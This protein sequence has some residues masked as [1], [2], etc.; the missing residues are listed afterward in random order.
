MKLLRTPDERFASLP[1]Y[2]FAPHYVDDL[3]GYAGLRIHYLDAGPRN[4]AKTYLCLHGQPTWSYLYRHMIPVFA[5]AGHR[6]VA[7]DFAGFGKSDKPADDADYT[8]MF[9]REMLARLIERLDLSNI[10]LVVQDWGGLIGLTLPLEMPRRFA[11]LLIMN[12]AFATGD[13]PLGQGFLDWRAWSNKNPD[14]PIG[15]LMSRSMPHLTPGELAAYDA[16]FPDATYKGGVRRFPNLVPERPDAE[17]AA[18]SRRARDWWREEWDGK[19][20]MAVGTQDPVLGPP[21]MA[22][23]RSQIR[24]CPPPLVIAEGGHFVQ[25]W[26]VPIA[27]A[28]LQV[29]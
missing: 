25:E 12:T 13:L 9:H 19:S 2:D 26:G 7:P 29:L 27:R 16:P 24:N 15:K 10:V 21:V 18:L 1:G 14:M 20:L 22:Y 4:A 3:P 23:V 28:A 8:F 6:V 11:G 17:G 5:G